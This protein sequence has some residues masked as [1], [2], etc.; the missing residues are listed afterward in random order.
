MAVLSSGFTP[1]VC[2]TL[3]ILAI[4][5]LAILVYLIPE[6][7]K[8]CKVNKLNKSRIRDKRFASELLS[9]YFKNN[10]IKN[11]YLLRSDKD[12]RPDADLVVVCEGGIV[13]ISVEDRPG[14][15]ETPKKGIWTLS[16]YGEV[17]RIPN[18]FERGMFYVSAC[19]NIARRNGISCPIFNLVLLSDDTADYDKGTGDGVIT[20]D[21]LVACIRSIK[22]KAKITT[23][24]VAK[25]VELLQQNDTYCRKLFVGKSY[26]D[27]FIDKSEPTPEIEDTADIELPEEDFENASDKAASESEE[28]TD[29]K[30]N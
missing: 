25:L 13:V 22:R 27:G 18:L 14:F 9:L 3:V 26:D 4:A 10:V 6:I 24:E 12:A 11:P 28:G 17:K 8:Y 1:L 30:E 29:T 21:I 23:E 20:N 2:V 15:Y 7:I 16:N 19:A 5:A